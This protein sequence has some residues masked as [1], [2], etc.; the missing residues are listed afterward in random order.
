MVLCSY[1]AY[2]PVRSLITGTIKKER[3]GM[4]WIADGCPI[5]FIRINS[6]AILTPVSG[7]RLT[8]HI[9]KLS[10]IFRFVY[11]FLKMKYLLGLADHQEHGSAD[12][13][14]RTAVLDHMVYPA[15]I[16]GVCSCFG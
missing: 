13:R 8:P 15:T 9:Q 4:I 7:W 16:Y 10:K 6:C 14:L 5:Y 11:F 1:G 2:E 3:V 12:H